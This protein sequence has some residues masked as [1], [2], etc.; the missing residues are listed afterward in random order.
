LKTENC[1]L[2]IAGIP[3]Q[4]LF[5]I[6]FLLLPAGCGGCHKSKPAEEAKAPTSTEMGDQH[7]DK[8]RTLAIDNLNS[9]EDFSSPDVFRQIVERL[10]PHNGPKPGQA[11][12]G[13]DPLL[14]CWPEPEMLPQVVDRLNQWIHTQPTSIDWKLDPMAAGLPKPLAELPQVK[15]LGEME[16]PRMDGYALQE[17]VWLRDISRWAGGDVIDELER[18]KNLFDWTVRNIQLEPDGP[19]RVPQFPWETLLFGR[20][21]ATD[22][23]WVFILLLRQLNID[24]AVLALDAGPGAKGQGPGTRDEG[25]GAK[26]EKGLQ[27]WCVGVLIEGNVYLFDPLPGLPI[28]VPNGVTLDAAG[29]LVIQPATLAQVVADGKLLRGMDA[30]EAHVYG[31]K[32]S[33]LVRVTA[34]LEASPPYL[35]R[36]MKLLESRLVPAQKMVLTMSPTTHAGR[37]KDAK[38][39]AEV[40]LWPQPFVVLRQRSGINWRGSPMWLRDVLPLYMVYKERLPA[41]AKMPKD[42]QDQQEPEEPKGPETITYAAPLYKGRVLYLKGKF[43]GDNGATRYYQIARPSNETLAISSADE[44]EKQIKWWGK[45]DASYWSGLVAYQLARQRG[46]NNY[47]AAMDYFTRRTLEA[48]PDGPWTNGARYNLARAYE[49]SGQTARA[50]LQYGSND[51]SPGYLGDLLRAKWLRERGEGRRVAR[52]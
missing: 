51:S 7:S 30:D 48:Y 42:P 41:R 11:D 20:G 19:N 40:R 50:I 18:A 35:A 8:M 43:T 15:N 14:A 37:W 4:F 13:G 38:H 24:A 23:A 3:V 49:A 6:L 46:K 9:L 22:R 29:Q 52:P 33:E 32:A 26:A 21:T 47:D 17:A 39:V 44:G 1:Q 45:Q 28:P 25:K 31:V 5:C 34:L 16:F 10:D 27:P 12:A 36:R 2:R